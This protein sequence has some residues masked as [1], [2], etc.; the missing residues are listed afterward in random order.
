MIYDF[1]DTNEQD[2]QTYLPSEAVSI[3]G[4]YLENI[5]TGYRTLYVKGRESLEVEL[6]KYS[7]GTA[8]GER[9]KGRR[10]P[11]RMLTIGFQLIAKDNADFRFRFNQLNN[12]LAIGEADFV[13]ADE[14][15]KFFAGFPVMNA[16]VDPGT[17]AVTGEWQIFCAYPYKRST[18]PTVLSSEDST[19]VVVGTNSAT[20]TFNYDGVI[21][22]RP[23]LRATFAAAKEGGDYNEDGDCGFIAFMTDDESIIQLGNPDV[24]DVDELNKNGTL[25]NSEFDN[26]TNWTADGITV[27]SI[28]DPY[29]NRGAGQTKNYAGGVGSLSRS[30]TGAVGFEF[31]IVQR[32]CVNNSSQVGSFKAL[33]K[34]GDRVIVGYIIEKTGSGTTATVKYIVNDKVVG[35]DNIDI[36]YYNTSFGYCNRTPVYVQQTYYEQVVT[37]VTETYTVKKKGKKKKKTRV[38]PVYSWEARIRTVQ[39]GWNYTQSNLNSGIS[40]D[41]GVVTFSVGN[42]ADR[43]FKS[44]DIE[45]TP[46]YDVVLETTGSFH[47]NAVRSAALIGKAG[48]PFAD[49]PN[50][51][52]AGDIVEADCNTANVYLYRDSSVTGHEEP[53]YG[54]LGNDWEDFNIKVGPNIIK[55]VWSDWVNTNY[56]PKIEIIFN[57]VYI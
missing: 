13:F 36:S 54:A 9:V 11:S 38:V 28:A 34:N 41:G 56:K 16:A 15:D 51:F 52:T 20:F 32:L 12:I 7:V 43:T 47:T 23:L 50:V 35:T 27:R 22:A 42:L 55:A 46:I 48:V 53:Q 21:P 26:L 3:N 29:W 24:I 18:T 5:I 17:N 57:E 44:S 33:L 2:T 19:G 4:T 37:Y 39:S 45:N 40:R 6:D 1:V 49:I 31:D 10:Y 30:T 25:I 8:D 14:P